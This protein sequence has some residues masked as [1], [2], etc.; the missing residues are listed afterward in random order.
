MPGGPPTGATIALPGADF[1][2]YDRSSDR[3][4]KVLGYF[5]TAS[6]LTQLG[7]Q[8]HISPQDM[9]PVTKF[10]IGLRVDSQREDAPGA[11]TVTWIDID[12][13]Y[14]S[15]LIEATTQ[16]V[17]ELLANEG[18]LGSCFATIGRRNY[19]FSAWKSPEAARSALR[20][21]QH[22][23]GMRLAKRGGL[24]DSARGITSIWVPGVLNGI[25]RPG[26]GKSDDLAELGG[27]WL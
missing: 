27:Q 4:S 20:G 11:L 6:M 21:G 7:L 23:A 8:A 5:D 12:P 10:G 25:F 9:E 17:M 3:L 13:E 22:A 14:A 1:I 16:I 2:D 18:Y 15:T 19:T 24:G 26:P